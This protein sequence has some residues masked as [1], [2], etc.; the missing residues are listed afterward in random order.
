[1]VTPLAGGGTPPVLSPLSLVP[2][3][4]SLVV[5]LI[6]PLSPALPLL[7]IFVF[8]P[9]PE[10]KSTI[11]NPVFRP[12]THT[13]THAHTHTRT[14]TLLPFP[15]LLVDPSPSNPFPQA[16]DRRK[17]TKK[18]NTGGKKKKPNIGGFQDWRQYVGG[19]DGKDHRPSVVG[20][21]PDVKMEY[22]DPAA[23]QAQRDARAA[24]EVRE[25]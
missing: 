14:H 3:P 18:P 2:G 19:K 12:L 23:L 22:A 24:M 8:P 13:R 6:A 7:R 21:R 17:K 16:R 25:K 15:S 10:P 4:L 5:P 11:Q 20:P 9:V 1:M